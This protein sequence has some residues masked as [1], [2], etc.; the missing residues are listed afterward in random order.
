MAAVREIIRIDEALCNGCGAC[1]PGCPEGAIQMIDGKA[2][3]VSDLFCDGLGAC[4]GE[5]PQGA[6]T[7]ERREAEAYDE[8]QVMANI[9]KAGPNTIKA[10]LKHLK[11]HNETEYFRQACA[12]L[13][14]QGL[15]IPNLDEN[16][17]E[18]AGCPGSRQRTLSPDQASPQPVGEVPS[19]LGQW[20]IQLHLLMPQSSFL[21]NADL[22]L[23][24]DCT[25]YAFGN[26]HD[27]FLKGKALAVAC[28]KLDTGL[29]EYVDKLADMIDLSG[30]KSI[31]VL[32]M[33]VPCCGGLARIAFA[34][35]DKAVRKIPI[36][37]QTVSID[38]RILAEELL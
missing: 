24:A 25:A 1:V 11:D 5:C 2:R 18:F 17:A 3:L 27:H 22:L 30:L 14:Q 31:H 38:G 32:R 12:V 8:A 29:D 23:A 10:H 35:R 7:I 21:K 37:S 13:V 16:K 28:P 26:F 9:I 20:P 15:S 4:I 19:R 34:A 6:I 33:E 36:L